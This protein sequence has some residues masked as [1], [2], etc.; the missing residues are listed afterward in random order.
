MGLNEFGNYED[1]R[2]TNTLQSVVNSVG[3]TDKNLPEKNVGNPY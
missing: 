2:K 1:K 3:Q